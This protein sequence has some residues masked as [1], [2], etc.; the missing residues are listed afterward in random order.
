MNPTDLTKGERTAYAQGLEILTLPQL[1]VCYIV[2]KFELNERVPPFMPMP[3]NEFSVA[4]GFKPMTYKHAVNKFKLLLQGLGEDEEATRKESIRPKHKLAFAKFFEMKN[5]EV[6][7]VA[8]EAFTEENERKGL[9]YLYD[10][11]ATV[12]A[13]ADKV[14]Q[15]NKTIN[16]FLSVTYTD[17]KK[18]FDRDKAVSITLQKCMEKF[19]ITLLDAKNRWSKL[20][21]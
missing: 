1:A 18:M 6:L 8:Q 19:G 4:G 15:R 7:E 21:K 13:S 14:K 10:S 2:A 9:V 3:A 17:Y 11:K 12:E 20:K 16:T 5:S